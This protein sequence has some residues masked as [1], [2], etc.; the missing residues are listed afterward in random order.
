MAHARTNGVRTPYERA[1]AMEGDWLT[2]AEAAERLN[3]TPEAVRQKA[4]R[5]RW[6]RTIGND[7]RARVRLPD[8]WTNP[9]RTPSE[10]PNKTEVRT[11]SE[12]RPDA[13]LIKALEA[14]VETLKEQLAAAEARIDKQ[15]D[16][17]VAYDTAYADGLAAERAKVEA[18]RAKAERVIA[19]FAARDAQH[20]ADL[21]GERARTE[22]AIAAFASLA[23]RL[24]ALAAERAKPW[25]RRLV[26]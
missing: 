9:V 4:I 2:Y 17:L 25:W 3:A 21:A 15:A 19:E 1:S 7:K 20:A 24:D 10:H 26:G 8:G 14:H 13:Q 16:D 18:E 22:K 11:P 6:Q 5:G 12:P 23:D